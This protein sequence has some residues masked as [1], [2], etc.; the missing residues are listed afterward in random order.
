MRFRDITATGKHRSWLPEWG[1][2]YSPGFKHA[3]VRP[4]LEEMD[5]KGM[6]GRMFLDCGSGSKKSDF[7]PVNGK[8]VIRVDVGMPYGYSRDGNVLELRV[9]VETLTLATLVDLYRSLPK[10]CHFAGSAINIVPDTLIVVDLLNYVNFRDVIPRLMD[11]LRYGGRAVI[12]NFAGMGI[13]ELLS[14]DGVKNNLQFLEFLSECKFR[15]EHL[16]FPPLFP[17]SWVPRSEPPAPYPS[18][19][20]TLRDNGS[21]ILV[22]VK[23]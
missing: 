17:P 19:A 14:Q 15:L 12:S 11:M 8:R 6:L 13:T 9:D 1:K 22:L 23:D 21:M 4:L 7:Y 5:R 10:E 18:I 3:E 2:P 20:T 16:T